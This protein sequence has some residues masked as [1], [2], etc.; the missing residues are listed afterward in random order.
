[1]LS[2]FAEAS[3]AGADTV[4]A[5]VCVAAQAHDFAITALKAPKSLRVATGVPSTAKITVELQN[6]SS[7]SE[8]IDDLAQ[9][10]DLVA[11]A[12]MPSGPGCG[13]AP[14]A[15]D[16]NSA[17]KLP[18]ELASKKKLKVTFNATISCS[19]TDY[20]V[21]AA[22][23]HSALDGLPD[24]H[25]ADDVCPRGAL[26]GGVDPNPDGSV[27]D[28]GCGA[29]LPDGTLGADVVIDVEPD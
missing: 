17:K 18:I 7:H 1:V 5:A 19:A 3:A 6:R 9:L 11:L 22:V 28:K 16:P 26:P 14:V 23:D 25:P 12:V 2:Q 8:V 29:K 10:G 4:Q 24:S 27:K 13:A 15:L 21:D 20:V